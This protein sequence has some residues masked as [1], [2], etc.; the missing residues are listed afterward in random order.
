MI[1]HFIAFLAILFFTTTAEAQ[2]L[3]I[4]TFGEP[5]DKPIIYLHGGPGY[6]CSNFE[7]STAQKLSAQ[8]Y[9]VIVYDRR[10]E[11]RSK[12]KN[13]RFNFTEAF[14]DINSLYDSFH[15]KKATLFGHSFGG[16]VATLYA[17]KFANKV[18]AVVLIG[19]PVSLQQTFKT[20]INKCKNIYTS[21]NDTLNLGYIKL[22]ETMDTSSLQYSSYCFQHAMKNGF[23]S[24][25]KPTDEAKSIYAALKNDSLKKYF[26]QMTF[27]GPQGFHK[28]ESYTTID[29]TVKI[30][31]IIKNNIPVFG[32]YG[33]EDG[34]YSEQ[35]IATLEKII[36]TGN[37]KYFENCSHNVFTD[38]QSAFFNTLKTWIK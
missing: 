26:S 16:V 2:T 24:P 11:G 37:L 31:S 7:A 10:G 28:N 21:K 4:K 35:Q 14:Q 9:Y 30:K 19:A 20:I 6:N 1:K 18:A 25:A 32:F 12:D 33:K 15:I 23:Y 13:A 38:Q 17:E 27:Q 22:L 3:Y 8:G 29:L 34:L 5:A 36:G